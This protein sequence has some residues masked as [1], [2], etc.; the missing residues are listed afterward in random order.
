M[1]VLAP[2]GLDKGLPLLLSGNVITGLVTQ[3]MAD[4][5][6]AAAVGPVTLSM[7]GL[8]HP[9][10]SIIPFAAMG[11]AYASS[12]AYCLVIGTPPNAI[13]YA[14]G[15]LEPR[16]YIRVGVILWFTNLAAMLLLAATYWRWM[17]WSGLTPF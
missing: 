12:L 10:S 17:G 6:A 5:P 16:D 15:Y 7:A 9:G 1:D 13:V 11:T 3:I 8:A 4:G 14:S 2:F